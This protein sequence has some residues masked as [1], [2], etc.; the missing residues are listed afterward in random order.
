M[1][2]INESCTTYSLIGLIKLPKIILKS[3]VNYIFIL[4]LR[5]IHVFVKL[6]NFLN[7]KNNYQHKIIVGSW[8][9][10]KIVKKLE[11]KTH[12]W[13][14]HTLSLAHITNEIN[15]FRKRSVVPIE[16]MFQ[17]TLPTCPWFD[18]IAVCFTSWIPRKERY[19][20]TTLTN[21]TNSAHGPTSDYLLHRDF[22]MAYGTVL[23]YLLLFISLTYC[24]LIYQDG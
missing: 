5:E 3:W 7:I 9:H 18:W 10:G 23:C 4:F 22:L 6:K 2:C 12:A 14:V 24:L 1:S 13:Y 20:L 16:K 19:V 11:I 15:I 17:S 8:V 21:Y